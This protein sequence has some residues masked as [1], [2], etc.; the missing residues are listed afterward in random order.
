MHALRKERLKLVKL[1]RNAEQYG[2]RN[3]SRLMKLLL[4]LPEIKAEGAR[5]WGWA[6][7][8]KAY[9]SASNKAARGVL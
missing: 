1:K 2:R 3:N 6:W 7:N 8:L 5:K 4:R 9:S